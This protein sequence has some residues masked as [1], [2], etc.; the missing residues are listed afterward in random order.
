MGS[1]GRPFEG[2]VE[3]D[4]VNPVGRNLVPSPRR[5]RGQQTTTDISSATYPTPTEKTWDWSGGAIAGPL[6][7]ERLTPLEDAWTLFW[8]AWSVFYPET[9]LVI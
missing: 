7:G 8:F 9:R 5:A 3:I 2:A 4:P 6:Q 1:Q